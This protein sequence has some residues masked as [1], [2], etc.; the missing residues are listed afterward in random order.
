MATDH[1]RAMAVLQQ[2]MAEIPKTNDGAHW[3]RAI[4]QRFVRGELRWGTHARILEGRALLAFPAAFAGM[5]MDP[6]DLRDQ[7]FAQGW[8]EM[9]AVAQRLV[10]DIKTPEGT[11]RGAYFSELLTP[12]WTTVKEYQP[13]LNLSAVEA[14]DAAGE[15]P[16]SAALRKLDA[17]ITASAIGGPARSAPAELVENLKAQV[18]EELREAGLAKPLGPKASRNAIKERSQAL[19][20]A[21]LQIRTRREFTKGDFHLLVTSSSNPLLIVQKDAEGSALVLMN[22]DYQEPT[23]A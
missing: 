3:V 23:F 6:A 17:P 13:L 22:P 10:V 9:D 7:L 14:A 4:V 5:G 11:L 21:L 8:I 12:V 16:G 19:G 1:E 20:K 2:A 15:A 18:L